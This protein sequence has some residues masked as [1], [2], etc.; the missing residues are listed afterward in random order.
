MEAFTVAA[1]EE[2]GVA[3][4][5]RCLL[6]QDGEVVGETLPLGCVLAIWVGRVAWVGS[7]D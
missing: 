5:A 2:E 1:H 6:V 3:F 7:V 4:I